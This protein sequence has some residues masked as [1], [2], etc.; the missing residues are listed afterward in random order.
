MNKILDENFDHS[1]KYLAIQQL[2]YPD[3]VI[4]SVE[5]CLARENCFFTQDLLTCYEEWRMKAVGK[6]CGSIDQCVWRNK[7]LTGLWSKMLW[8]EILIDKGILYLSHFLGEDL[9][10]YKSLLPHDQFLNKWNLDLHDITY[11]DYSNIRI[12]IKG[13][14]RNL[15]I[16]NN[17]D[18][19]DIE[20]TVSKVFSIHPKPPVKECGISNLMTRYTCR[21]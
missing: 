11:N 13:Y 6:N 1:W 10:N 2:S 18:L 19:I 14:C 8:S 3:Q 9:H 20:S 5:N 4:I 16:L 12:A 15:G 17:F 21:P 7:A